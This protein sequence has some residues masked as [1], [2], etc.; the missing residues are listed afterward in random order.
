[1]PDKVLD[2]EH[3]PVNQMK[4]ADTETCQ[5]D[6]EIP[7]NGP[8]ADDEDRTSTAGFPRVDLLLE[9]AG[10]SQVWAGAWT[11]GGP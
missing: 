9:E 1:M 4:R 6:G 2:A 7:S 10:Q 3:V 8:G 11:T 5:R